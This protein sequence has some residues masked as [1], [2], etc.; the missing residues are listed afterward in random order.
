MCEFF[1]EATTD[2]MVFD[3][4]TRPDD[5]LIITVYHCTRELERPRK[6][7]NFLCTPSFELFTSSHFRADAA[8]YDDRLQQTATRN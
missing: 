1:E 3:M 4:A 2:C 8:S 6:A 5:K 7:V